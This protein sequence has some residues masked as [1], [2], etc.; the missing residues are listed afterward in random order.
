MLTELILIFCILLFTYILNLPFGILRARAKRFSLK[1]F[2]YIHIPIPFIF[3]LRKL[4]N[5]DYKYIPLFVFAAVIG[6][7]MGG[8]MEF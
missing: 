4:S 5:L 8:K 2:L 6:Q 1:W 7:L 3:L